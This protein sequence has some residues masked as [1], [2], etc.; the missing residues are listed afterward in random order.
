MA[1]FALDLILDLM[2]RETA[3]DL[4]GPYGAARGRCSLL[5]A[6]SGL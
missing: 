4:V 2:F 5:V 6:R 3:L 1:A